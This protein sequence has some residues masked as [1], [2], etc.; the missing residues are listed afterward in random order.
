M[1]LKNFYAVLG[2]PQ[3]ATGDEIRAA[4]RKLAKKYH[5]DAAPDNPF[6]AAQFHRDPAGL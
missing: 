1:S 5:P 2:V 6:A 4:F 3:S